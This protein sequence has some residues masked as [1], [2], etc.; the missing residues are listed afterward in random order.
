MS[1]GLSLD[2]L[3]ADAAGAKLRL[4]RIEQEQR[5]AAQDWL[6]RHGAALAE[7]QRTYEE[8]RQQLHMA[9]AAQRVGRVDGDGWRALIERRTTYAIS[10]ERAL[11]KA[12]DEQGTLDSCLSLDVTKIKRLIKDGP[13][14]GWVK[15][16]GSNL[17]LTRWEGGD[18]MDNGHAPG[19]D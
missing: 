17:R 19:Q 16:V 2:Q 8:A 9:M 6:A 3:I 14:P 4:E 18:A 12:L 13:M 10:D 11:R 1:V 7:L 5:A 15:T